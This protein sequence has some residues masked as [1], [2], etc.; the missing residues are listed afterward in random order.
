MCGWGIINLL[1]TRTIYR[2]A[3]LSLHPDT[4]Y[5][6]GLFLGSVLQ[7]VDR[8]YLREYRCPSCNKL[9][10]KGFLRDK[11]SFLE[12]K[13]RGCGHLATFQGEDKEI[14]EVR[15]ELLQEGSIPD[16]E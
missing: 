1:M 9:L 2:A 11:Q 5:Y 6:C 12:V 3:A 10:S 13:C 15:S 4:L 14:I 16:T 8:K 7:Q